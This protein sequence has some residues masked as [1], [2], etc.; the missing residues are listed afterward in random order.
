MKKSN[1]T[2]VHNFLIKL[3]VF[4]E[5]AGFDPA[6]DSP[7]AKEVG[8]F[9]RPESVQTAFAQASQAFIAATDYFEALDTLVKKE[10]FAI[11]PWSCARGMIESSA[12]C[13]WLFEIGIG[14]KE[15]VNRSLS[16]RY[17]ALREQEKMARY[18][19]NINKIK[20]IEDRI[21]SIERIAVNLGFKLLRDKK[22]RRIGI[23]QIK[24]NMTTLIESQFKG[25]KL[26]R[27][28]SG[29]AHSNYT[30]LTALSFTKA[31]FKRKNGAVIVRAVP[32]ELQSSLVSHAATI[33]A[34]CLWLRTIQF[35]FDAAHAAVLL[36]ELYDELKLADTNEN[37]F[38]R[39]IISTGS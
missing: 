29:M 21:V 33:Y 15:R 36:E 27:M 18:D 7:A 37:R 2:P 11:A 17:A 30:T 28:L 23:G 39:T 13:T 1:K 10:K 25:E 16:L 34:K 31:D 12:L 38:W 14:P 35:G 5:N 4:L 20:E 32:T 26:Y 24:P 9:S 8:A 22:N 3:F 6:A 19:R